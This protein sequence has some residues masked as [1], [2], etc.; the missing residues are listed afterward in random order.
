MSFLILATIATFGF[1]PALMSRSWNF[2]IT[3]L[4]RTA[5]NVAMYSTDLT[6]ARP[7][8]TAL[9]PL[10]LPLSLLKGATP[11]KAEI[12]RFSSLPNSGRLV[13]RASDNMGPT[14]GTLF[15]I[16]SCLRHMGDCLIRFSSSSSL[17]FMRFSSHLIC[18]SMSFLIFVRMVGS[19]F[20]S[21]VNMS[22]SCLRRVR[23]SVSSLV[24]SS[25]NGRISGLIDSPKRAMMSAS[26]R[27]VFASVP[28][29]FAKF[30]IWRGLIITTGNPAVAKA[31]ATGISSP[32]V[33]SNTMRSGEISASLS[34]SG[35]NSFSQLDIVQN[36]FPGRDAISNFSFATSIPTTRFTSD[37]FLV[38]YLVDAGLVSLVT[39]RV[40]SEIDETVNAE[41][42]AYISH[43]SN[44]LSRHNFEYFSRGRG[45][46][47]E[48]L[49]RRKLPD[50]GSELLGILFNRFCFNVI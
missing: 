28:I 25:F 4:N 38:P 22:T 50:P 29:A 45:G 43:R 5:T 26:M 15:T 46:R 6:F 11:T 7:P 32:P 41:S 2:L 49:F 12:F 3:G 19:R 35:P 8:H 47:F 14:P 34:I 39:V 10:N 33:A 42:R 17:S 13:K 48:E 18:F 30:L 37:I 40:N 23:T 1:L 36:A 20:F 24:C 44:D 21:A 31:E 27:S 9:V 16:S